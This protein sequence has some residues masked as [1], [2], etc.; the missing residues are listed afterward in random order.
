MQCLLWKEGRRAGPVPGQV[1]GSRSGLQPQP[2]P[3][4]RPALWLQPAEQPP[5]ESWLQLLPQPLPQHLP[6]PQPPAQPRPQPPVTGPSP[7]CRSPGG[8]RSPSPGSR[9]RPLRSPGDIS[10]SRYVPVP[11]PRLTSTSPHRTKVGTRVAPACASETKGRQRNSPCPKPPAHHP[12]PKTRPPQDRTPSKSRVSSSTA[13]RP[14]P[15]PHRKAGSHPQPSSTHHL[16]ATRTKHWSRSE[17]TPRSRPGHGPGSRPSSQLSPSRTK[18]LPSSASV[19]GREAAHNARLTSQSGSSAK[20]SAGS[21][22]ASAARGSSGVPVPKA[23]PRE[24]PTPALPQKKSQAKDPKEVVLTRVEG[25]STDRTEGQRRHTERRQRGDDRRL[26]E[27][28]L[29][30]RSSIQTSEEEEEEEEGGGANERGGRQRGEETEE[31]PS[32]RPTNGRSPTRRAKIAESQTAE[33]QTA[34][35]QTAGP[36]GAGP[37]APRPG[38]NLMVQI[39]LCLLKRVPDTTTTTTTTAN[40]K[41]PPTSCPSALVKTSG[42]MKHFHGP[43]VDN[44]DSRRKRKSENGV[45]H[46]ESKRGAPYAKDPAASALPPGH[47][48]PAQRGHQGA[49][50]LDAS[51]PDRSV[52]GVTWGQHSPSLI[53][54]PQRIHQMAANHLNITNSVLYSFEYWEVADTLA[55]ENKE[56]FN[57]LNTLSGPLTLLSSISQAVQYTRERERETLPPCLLDSQKPHTN[58][59]LNQR[60]QRL[61]VVEQRPRVC[62]CVAVCVVLCVCVVQVF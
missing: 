33:P 15:S 19:S 7:R 42:T 58:S 51:Q 36:G 55:K 41:Q 49:V 9:R 25:W 6:Q 17:H 56:F 43:E 62:V 45:S 40:H 59:S 54:I 60:S 16:P 27:E 32:P 11:G 26:A 21:S 34:Q 48:D 50:L 57:Y 4:P 8:S 12:R 53:S 14:D 37:K 5:A 46:R 52:S 18:Q 30:R 13:L 61:F 3:G 1:L 29:R 44:R 24:D 31:K 39:E 2:E 35:P 23:K 38:V 20:A 47:R 22:A 10:L 28:Q